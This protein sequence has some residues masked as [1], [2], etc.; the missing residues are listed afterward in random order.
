MTDEI[1][2]KELLLKFLD[3][4]KDVIENSTVYRATYEITTLVHPLRPRAGHPAELNWNH[5][6]YKL[7]IDVMIQNEVWTCPDCGM[8]FPLS[9]LD[10]V[11]AKREEMG[12]S[13]K[14]RFV[15]CQ[16]KGHHIPGIASRVYRLT[17]KGRKILKI[18][19]NGKDKK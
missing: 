3:D 17:D 12:V 19:R 4:L 9:R 8:D 10:E 2:N 18:L 7:E 11:N 5:R 1:K 6:R 16:N 15:P 14:A 13:I